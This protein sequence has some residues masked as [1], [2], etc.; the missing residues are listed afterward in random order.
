MNQLPTPYAQFIFKSRYS[1]WRDDLG[2]REHWPETVDRY[3]DWITDGLDLGPYAD[4][5][6][7]D[8]IL[9][10]D[11]MPSMRAL[12]SAGEAADRNNIAIYNCAYTPIDHLKRFGEIL[13]ILMNGT[14]VGFSVERRYIGSLPPVPGDLRE[15]TTSLIVGDSKEGWREAVDHLI[16]SVFRLGRIPKFDLSLIRPKGARLKTFGGRASGPGPLSDML[17][18]LLRILKDRQG[19]TLRSIDVYDMVCCIAQSVVVGGVRRAAL[20]SLSDLDDALMRDCKNGYIPTYRY[21]SNNSAVYHETPDWGTFD[22]EFDALRRS[23]MGERGI[24]NRASCQSICE[25]IGR[26][27]RV[28]RQD[29]GCNPCFEII[30]RPQQFCNLTEVV[31]REGDTIQQLIAKVEAAAFFGTL[32]ARKTNFPG[33]SPEWAQTTKDDALL[34]VSLTGCM[35]RIERLSA[36]DLALLRKRAK[37]INR[38]WAGRLGIAPAAAITCVKPSGTVSQLV[39]SASGLHPRYARQYIRRVRAD[40]T[41]PLARFLADQGVHHE[42]CAKQGDSTLVFSFPMRSPEGAATRHDVTAIDQLEDW[43][44]YQRHWCDHKP[45]LTCYVRDHEW[46]EVADWVYE[47]FNEMSGVAFFPYSDPN[48]PQLPYEEVDEQVLIELEAMTPEL[49]WDAFEK[50]E[51]D[52]NTVGSQTLACSGGAC[53]VVDLKE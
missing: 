29:W 28:G 30:L 13:L 42:P 44:H 36:Y 41:D 31:V 7:R 26:D 20:C 49:D 12:M 50:Y 2:R 51:S 4:D 34:G 33:L 16:E 46:D 21:L 9:S 3:Y 43:L 39:D 15:G 5:Y 37:V 52:D 38:Y 1:R 19:Q 27:L 10:T 45:S 24:F 32:Q 6:G 14:G 25:S 40:A 53:E 23:N 35:D 8:L 47:H 22:E 18:E 11:V 17:D 48:Y